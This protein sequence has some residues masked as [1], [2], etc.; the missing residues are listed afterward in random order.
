MYT[1]YKLYSS[2]YIKQTHYISLHC[3]LFIC[4]VFVVV[5]TSPVPVFT[6]FYLYDFAFNLFGHN[7]ILNLYINKA[8]CCFEVKLSVKYYNTHI[9]MQ[10]E[11]C[12][13]K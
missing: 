7:K 6:N 3:H 1:Y 8:M 2:L 11:M 4:L 13:K 12:K 9:Q 5:L 10:R